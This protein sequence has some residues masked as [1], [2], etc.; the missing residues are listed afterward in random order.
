MLSSAVSAEA[1]GIEFGIRG[2]GGACVRYSRK[3]RQFI[4]YSYCCTMG[5]KAAAKAVQPVHAK[6]CLTLS[7]GLLKSPA[8]VETTTARHDDRDVHFLHVTGITP[9]LCLMVCGEGACKRPLSRCTIIGKLRKLVYGADCDAGSGDGIR[10][11]G[12]ADGI[13]GGGAKLDDDDK[14]AALLDDVG[15]E[16]EL[17][18]TPRAK[19]HR[20]ARVPDEVVSITV[21]QSAVACDPADAKPADAVPADA[22][23]V[24][25]VVDVLPADAGL[26]ADAAGDRSMLCLRRK[27]NRGLYI[28]I[29]ALSWL[30]HTLRMERDAGGVKLHPQKSERKTGDIWWDFAN[31]RW[32]CAVQVADGS[33]Q[34]RGQPVRCR[35]AS[36]LSNMTF[37]DA[38]ARVYEEMKAW[39]A[40]Q[41]Q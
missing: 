31:S 38:K 32:N 6:W 4:N 23:S 1:E 13:R 3:Q 33:W 40:E 16:P 10:G 8:A 39:R 12:V 15:D 2:G 21:P 26:A 35:M 37:E 11:C 30:V 29:D 28:E 14:M 5:R 41:L 27:D 19:R 36:D 17:A 9:W 24:A 25:D 18:P 22:G 7:G 34:K 20:S